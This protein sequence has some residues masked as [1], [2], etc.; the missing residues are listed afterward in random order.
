L[1]DINPAIPDAFWLRNFALCLTRREDINPPF[2]DKKLLDV[3]TAQEAPNQILF[4]FADLD[5][6]ARAAP[7]E[8]FV[9][10]MSMVLTE[11]NLS[12]LHRR[13]M[14]LCATHCGVPLYGNTPTATC[15]Q[16]SVVLTL[17]L[18]PKIL[19]P[20]IDETGCSQT[21][22]LYLSEDAWE[23]LLGRSKQKLCQENIDVLRYLEQRMLYLRVSLGVAWW[24][25]E[26]DVGVGRV[27]VWEVRT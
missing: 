4:T 23:Q 12:L 10:W 25:E 27:W 21:G 14:L 1:I 16:C 2:P 9:G 3:K 8:K 7:T 15:K 11:I 19:G 13:S 24:A 22:K 18:N 6:F 26:V 17:R 20:V 5:E